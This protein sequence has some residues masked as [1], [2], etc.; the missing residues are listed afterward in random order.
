MIRYYPHPVPG[1]SG[2]DHLSYEVIE[3]LPENGYATRAGAET[4]WYCACNRAD[5]IREG[6]GYRS[7]SRPSCRVEVAS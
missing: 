2:A 7:V 6:H 1:T 3:Q 4:G 5:A